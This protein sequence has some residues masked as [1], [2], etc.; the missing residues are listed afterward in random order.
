M[1]IDT[2][3]LAISECQWTQEECPQG[4]PVSVTSDEDS[5]CAPKLFRSWRAKSLSRIKPGPTGQPRKQPAAKELFVQLLGKRVIED[6]CK[7]VPGC[8][9]ERPHSCGLDGEKQAAA[10]Q[11]LDLLAW[12]A[13]ALQGGLIPGD[14]SGKA[15]GMVATAE[16][17]RHRFQK[18]LSRPAL[19]SLNGCKENTEAQWEAFYNLQGSVSRNFQTLYTPGRPLCVRKYALSYKGHPTEC[20]LKMALLCEVESGY[21]CNFFLY[22]P[23]VLQRGSK[24]PVTEQ[25]LH[26]LL[27]PYYNKGYDVQLDSSARMEGRLSQI[28]SGLGV[29]L[30]FV[31]LGT[32][33]DNMVK[34][35]PSPPS[36]PS[37]VPPKKQ[38]DSGTE[39]DPATAP[40][41]AHF[42][43]WVG[44][45]LLPWAT[46]MWE[47]QS[48][49]FLPGFWL[50]VH[51]GCIDA[52]VLYS[53]RSRAPGNHIGL[54]DF[55]YGLA[56]ELA[57]AYL[58][59]TP[60][61]TPSLSNLSSQLNVKNTCPSR[62]VLLLL[63][64]LLFVV[65]ESTDDCDVQQMLSRN[66]SQMAIRCGPTT[67][68]LS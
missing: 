9:S 33:E 44:P 8:S 57:V 32:G 45:V 4:Q 34:P 58:P 55:T 31:D 35:F 25:V 65:V 61:A 12:T 28:F 29:H 14:G 47:H 52:F 38:G 66:H 17:W 53:L 1:A 68:T 26:R 64:L 23:E 27:R 30:Q 7:K 18:I 3:A 10:A 56:T 49:V 20:H 6:L 48:A 51:L 62:F 19:L 5:I 50:V 2:W 37:G 43:G 15:A 11:G 39:E 24:T 59:A 63:T 42:Q 46:E 13:V 60:Q 40:L 41:R 21:V 22:S 54:C 36:T 67:P 16:K